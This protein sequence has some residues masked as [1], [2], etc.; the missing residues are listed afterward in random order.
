MNTKFVKEPTEA[1]V[2]SKS[3]TIQA[4]DIVP[5]KQAKVKKGLRARVSRYITTVVAFLK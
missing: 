5:P 4:K 2:S 3:S 1:S